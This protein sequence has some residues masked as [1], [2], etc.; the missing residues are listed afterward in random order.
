MKLKHGSHEETEIKLRW[1]LLGELATWIGSSFVWPLTSVYLNKQLHISLSVIG[2]VLFCNCASNVLGSLLAGRLYDRLNPYPLIV[3]GL[4]LDALVLFLMAFFHGW[5][6]YWFWL[7]MTG[8][9]SGW[10]G[11]LINSIATSLRKYS[12]RYVF[13]LIYFAQNVGTVT[14]TLLVGYLYDFS[15]EF[16]FIL[17]ASLFAIACVNA[18]IHY[19][20]INTFHQNRKKNGTKKGKKQK[21]DPMPKYNVMLMV[22]FLV[23]L[24]VTW[25]M[26]MNWE[27]NL[28]VY[29]VSLGIPFH[30]YSLLWTLN[31]A[32]IVI[33]Q[34]ILAR[35]PNLFKSLFQQ[36]I[37]GTLMFAISFATLIFAK[38][39]AHFALSMFI[40]TMGEATAFPAVPAYIND[41][42]PINSKGKYQGEINV[43][44]GI[45]QAFGPLFG[46]MIIDRAGYI[47]FF[48]IAACG[49]FLVVLLLL[50]LHAKL[51]K[52]ITLYK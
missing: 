34:V 50:P 7:I 25:L 12:G 19:R 43:A 37:F 5:P 24:A 2:V 46:G 23:S 39:F 11:T 48:I 35:Y 28:S 17:A 49:I 6:E 31:G 14:G 52:H 44:R 20:P 26:Y 16:L 9:I 13:N 32:V 1:L 30:L 42:S 22:G 8:C 47:P 51:H 38:D 29:M 21:V 10:N 36:I 3:T 27:S 4:G 41:L 40:L 15:I 45:G 18:A 33:I